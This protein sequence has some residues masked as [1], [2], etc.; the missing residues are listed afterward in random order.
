MNEILAIVRLNKVSITKQALLEAGFPAF[1]CRKV[2]GRGKEPVKYMLDDN[3][4]KTSNL[5]PKRAFTLIVS[6]KDTEKVVN[7]LMNVNSTGS[8]GDGKIFIMPVL[9]SYKVST[10]EG[11]ADAF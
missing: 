11:S 2:F 10:G 3:I 8:H 1:T 5:M 7:V 4:E 6:E 9:E